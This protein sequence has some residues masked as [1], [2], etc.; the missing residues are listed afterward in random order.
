MK[1]S[2]AKRKTFQCASLV[3][4]RP[5]ELASFCHLV[6]LSWEH[7]A[8]SSLSV[9]AFCA[10][11]LIS[12]EASSRKLCG[13][14]GSA[15]SGH[16]AAQITARHAARGRLAHQMCI[17]E[18]C[19]CRMLFSRRACSEM[20]LMGRSTSIRRFGY[21]GSRLTCPPGGSS[22]LVRGSVQSESPM[23]GL[24]LLGFTK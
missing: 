8:A 13:Q 10:N 23:L 6:Q 15:G 3:E 4:S 5:P 24:G 1:S 14:S 19:P 16:S 21:G 17:V 20:R 22:Q 12:R 11:S 7:C 2:R 18:I 9:I